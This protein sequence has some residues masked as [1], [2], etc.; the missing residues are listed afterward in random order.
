M[1]RV[2]KEEP[3]KRRVLGGMEKAMERKLSEAGRETRPWRR[4]ESMTMV[5]I[6]WVGKRH[7]TTDGK[8]S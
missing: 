8:Y 4:K 7:G 6:V 2:F 5:D 3:G 1:G